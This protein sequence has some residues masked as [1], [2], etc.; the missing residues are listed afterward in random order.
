MESGARHV[1][2]QQQSPRGRWEA[3]CSL[4]RAAQYMPQGPLH[5]TPANR[6]L[7][8][9]STGSP[10]SQAGHAAVPCAS[11]CGQ[12]QVHVMKGVLVEHLVVGT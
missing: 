8:A 7:T 3:M 11:I 12:G 10:G 6:P 5:G 4:T 1:Q 9:L 2:H